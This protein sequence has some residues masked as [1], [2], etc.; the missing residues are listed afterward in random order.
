ME[1]SD[2]LRWK[3]SP[4]YTPEESWSKFLLEAHSGE[5]SNNTDSL[6]S[7][8]VPRSSKMNEQSRLTFKDCLV[9]GQE[10]VGV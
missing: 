5:R 7:N 2:P 10:N 8:D 4:S 1:R 9:F 6:L 3:V